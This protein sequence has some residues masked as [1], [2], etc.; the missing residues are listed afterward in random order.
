MLARLGLV[1]SPGGFG[2]V[3]TAKITK[4]GSCTRAISSL[5]CSM[6]AQYVTGLMCVAYRIIILGRCK[7]STTHGPNRQVAVASTYR[8]IQC[9]THST[10]RLPRSLERERPQ[11]SNG[12]APAAA[13]CAGRMSQETL[14]GAG[15]QSM[16]VCIT[17]KKEGGGGERRLKWSHMS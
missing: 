17:R 3:W 14:P 12:C 5:R 11:C 15:R 2:T 1:V 8:Y 9:E 6:S 10:P 7:A 4:T 16:W 13:R